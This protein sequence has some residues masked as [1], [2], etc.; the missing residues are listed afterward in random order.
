MPSAG[1]YPFAIHPVSQHY[2]WGGYDF[3]Y[4]LKPQPNPDNLPLAELWLGA[5]PKG[6]A[7]LYGSSKTLEDL[8]NESPAAYLG[9]PVAKRYVNRLPFL[10][11]V[12]EVNQML[13]IQVHPTKAAAEEGFAREEKIGPD[14][15]APNRNYRD[16]NHKPELG[17]AVT[18]FYLLHGFRSREAIA[19][20]LR[21][22]PGWDALSPVLEAGG[23]KGLYRHIMA[24]DQATVDALLQPLVDRVAAGPSDDPTTPEHWTGQAVEVY[25]KNG[26]HDRGI[27]SIYWFNILHLKPGQGIFQDAGVPHAYLRGVCVELMANSDNVL[28][29]GLTPKHIDVPELLKHT[30]CSTVTPAILQA[31]ESANA[32]GWLDYPTPAPDFALSVAR[33]TAGKMLTLP[34]EDRPSIVL[35]MKGKL[36]GVGIYLRPA[37]RFYYVPPG[38]S[39]TAEAIEDSEVYRATVGTA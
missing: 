21:E 14:R 17:V 22:V 23:V 24:A 18:D 13:S 28:R 10:L 6:A 19:K 34:A 20:T 15:T 11:K 31:G 3:L 30:D 33:A 26:H 35:L 1:Q 7:T 8:I 36:R 4:K 16:D 5:H 25:T 32:D 29:G 38:A 37:T 27:F 39:F 2:A 12:L 9:Q